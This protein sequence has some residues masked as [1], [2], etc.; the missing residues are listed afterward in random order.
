MRGL[1]DGFSHKPMVCW[2]EWKDIVETPGPKV[3]ENALP[4]YS[5]IAASLCN[6]LQTSKSDGVI[7]Q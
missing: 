3:I 5:V 7:V 6:C 2:S 1:E 4:L